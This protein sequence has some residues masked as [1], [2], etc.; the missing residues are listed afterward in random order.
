MWDTRIISTCHWAG[1][2][3]LK[4]GP[5]ITMKIPSPNGRAPVKGPKTKSLHQSTYWSSLI[6]REAWTKLILFLEL[7]SKCSPHFLQGY[8]YSFSRMSSPLAPLGP[9]PGW[10]HYRNQNAAHQLGM[11]KSGGRF[12]IMLH[13]LYGTTQEGPC[14]WTLT[15]AQPQESSL[16]KNDFPLGQPVLAPVPIPEADCGGVGRSYNRAL[17]CRSS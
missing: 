12:S 9:L 3:G 4:V 8:H 1:T 5:Q 6:Q 13:L 7:P 16:T 14:R 11:G 15:P 10:L 17:L 2:S